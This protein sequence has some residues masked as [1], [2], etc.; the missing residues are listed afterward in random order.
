MVFRNRKHPQIVKLIEAT[1]EEWIEECLLPHQVK[2]VH[3]CGSIA[4][5]SVQRFDCVVKSII[6]LWIA[7][8]KNQS[9]HLLFI[10]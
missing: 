10:T 4:F 5:T 6:Y 8:L 7:L 2:N 9:L 1:F 3:L